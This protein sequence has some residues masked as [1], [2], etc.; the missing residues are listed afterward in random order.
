MRNIFSFL[1]LILHLLRV[2]FF[3]QIFY[4]ISSNKNNLRFVFV[5]VNDNNPEVI[6]QY[7]TLKKLC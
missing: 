7:T 4:F 3:P 6:I 2:R 5:L 1:I